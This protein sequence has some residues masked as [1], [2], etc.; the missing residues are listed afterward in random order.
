MKKW[1]IAVL[2]V[3]IIFSA[4]FAFTQAD[5]QEVQFKELYR[6]GVELV[7]QGNYK[8]A[9][10][11]FEKALL[12]NPSSDLLRFMI[13]ET[14]DLILREMLGNPELNQTAQR[15]LELGKGAYERVRT[16]PEKIMEYVV[17]LD[18]PF[19]QKW[20]AVN[21]LAAIGQRAAPFLI[22]KM[23]D[24]SEMTRT[25]AMHALEKINTEAV[26]PLLEALQSKD[27]LVRQ[28]SAIVLGV[29]KDARAVPELKRVTEDANESMEVKRYAVE[30]L[31]KITGKDV[32]QLKSSKE[33]YYELGEKYYYRHPSVMINFY[34][35]SIVWKWD[36]SSNKLMMKEVP[37][38]TF[39]E[40]LAEECCYDGL[41]LDKNYEP[42]WTLLT[43]VLFAR[44]TEA[45]L[46]LQAALKK[47][48]T[49][50]I[51]EDVMTKL[52]SDLSNIKNNLVAAS[53]SG[54]D[55]FYKALER[56]LKDN[57]AEVAVACIKAIGN[58]AEAG[59]FPAA[60][61][62]EA[63]IQPIGTP[64]IDALSHSDKRVRYAA[65]EALTRIN[66]PTAFP[67]MEK[68]IPL[69]NEALGESGM[70]MALVIEPSTELRSYLK[71]ELN[72]LNIFIKETLSA[73]DGLK[74][75]K[76]FPSEDIIILN[77][78]VA[79]QVVFTLDILGRKYSETVYNS[80][81]DDIRTKGIPI[82][83]ID[84]AE[85]IEK[86]K[87]IYD[88]GI[89]GYLATPVDKAI[90]ADTVNK[91]LQREDIQVDSK[92][93]ALQVCADAAKVLA[94]LDLR[95]TIYPYAQSINALVGILENRPD[96]IRM[97][98]LLALNRFG[99]P[100]AVMGLSRALSNKENS[101]QIRK[102]AGEAIAN[103][104]RNKPSGFNQEVYEVLKKS[105]IEDEMEI[106]QVVAIALGNAKLTPTQRKELIDLKRPGFPGE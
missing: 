93:R 83:L 50:E 100:L 85:E 54:K 32:N 33:Y 9:Y 13:Q 15:I 78:R 97:S 57:N 90:L 18:G 104:L 64:L 80:L 75:A 61:K 98:A 36:A 19:D 28:N 89:E 23:A 2:V 72:K 65:A 59:D 34:G 30:S 62:K 20:E 12:L 103:I 41:T 66:P 60:D 95:N 102:K 101:L 10:I 53:L 5:D 6:K 35:E 63:K 29:I 25:N 105:L 56:S 70:R 39:N 7:K 46:A 27:I 86:A 38:F 3:S 51:A 1:F 21:M 4:T 96:D 73:D 74:A 24:K 47:S 58:A 87:G 81:K 92:T 94:N 16:S 26:L 42:L 71:M 14:G 17:N 67:N 48:R 22:E 11:N 106:K 77:S 49:G 88:E 43:C 40:L 82:I 52:Q 37:D 55:Y 68:V 69:I 99:N 79:N 84:T 8:D 76:A 31:G 91:V 44:Y 45:D